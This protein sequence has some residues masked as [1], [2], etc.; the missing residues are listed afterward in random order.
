MK[1]VTQPGVDG[2]NG[3]SCRILVVEDNPDSRA[4]LQVLLTL[5]GYEVEVA[6]DGQTGVH[7]A[8]AWRPDVAIVDIGLPVLDGYEVARRVRAALRDDIF[9]IALT[10]YNQPQDRQCAFAAGFD[11]HMA[12]PADLE[13]LSRLLAAV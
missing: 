1:T 4:S 9:L 10:A 6:A 3:T 11:L 7:K 5:W 12:K 8:L 13:E 2:E